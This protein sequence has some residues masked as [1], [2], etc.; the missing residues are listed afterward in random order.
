MEGM[1]NLVL[2]N[3]LPVLFDQFLISREHR[4]ILVEILSINMVFPRQRKSVLEVFPCSVFFRN[5][6]NWIGNVDKQEGGMEQVV[7]YVIR[8]KQV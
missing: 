6:D 2:F 7:G 8:T 5:T 1:G 4:C 3:H